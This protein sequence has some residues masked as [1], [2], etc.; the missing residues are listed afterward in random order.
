MN[1]NGKLNI[2]QIHNYYQQAGGEDTVVSNEK[3]LLEEAGYSVFTYYRSNEEVNK[4]SGLGKLSIPFTAVF[5][6]KSYREIKA[7]IKREHIDL[8]H[9]HNTHMVISPSAFY[10]AF[11]CHIPVVQTIHNFRLACPAGVFYRDGHICE[12]CLREGLGCSV[13]HS[14]YRGSKA[15]TFVNAAVTKLHRMLGTYRK[16]N[17]I[18]LTE[19]NKKKL[20]E[21]NQNGKRILSE[22]NIYIKPN[23]SYRET[24]K[25]SVREETIRN[26]TF[27]DESMIRS[28]YSFLF[29]G[30]LEPMK[31]IEFV[32]KAFERMPEKELNIAGSG[33]LLEE[34]QQYVL[35]Q[36]LDNIHFLGQ[37]QR[38]ELA[39]YYQSSAALVMASQ[40][41][42]GFPMVITEAYANGLPIIAGD[43]G[44]MS[45][46]IAPGKTGLL[47]RYDSLDAFIGAVTSLDGYDV[48]AM[49]EQAKAFYEERLSPQG[50]LAILEQIYQDI[51]E[52][53][54]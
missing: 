50:N 34:L 44:N 35:Q 37:L 20:L 24:S 27:L 48:L 36:K 14:C 30:R 38:D 41:Y 42:E 9:I 29:V 5:S 13:R 4:K 52:K 10:A 39:E 49:R 53:K 25:A 3:R 51:L 18:C 43:V 26:V 16:A 21:M 32:V 45:S 11:H 33:P 22:E 7:I 47:F 40:W 1:E 2:L 19:F 54:H 46:L 8:V 31:G 12:D 17:F 15:Q 6:W 28:N 23:F